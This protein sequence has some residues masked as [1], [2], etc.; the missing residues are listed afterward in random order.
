MQ[1]CCYIQYI[2]NGFAMNHLQNDPARTASCRAGDY[3]LLGDRGYMDDDGYVFFVGRAD[4]VISSAGYV[5]T[6]WYILSSVKA[7][8]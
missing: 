3:H 2:P 8:C 7:K 6:Y 5:C 4:D 1:V